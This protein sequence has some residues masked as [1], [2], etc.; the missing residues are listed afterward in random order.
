MTASAVLNGFLSVGITTFAAAGPPFAPSSAFEAVWHPA[1]RKPP[2]TSP[3][4]SRNT[5][6]LRAVMAYLCPPASVPFLVPGL[7]L[8]GGKER[9]TEV[10]QDFF[11]L[12]VLAGDGLL[13][14]PLELL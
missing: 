14:L 4:T 2:P 9:H 7:L 12:V 5:R 1:R 6:S 8:A 10:L 11:D 3:R 13:Q